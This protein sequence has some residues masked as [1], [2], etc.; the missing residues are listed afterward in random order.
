MHD[1]SMLPPSRVVPVVT[2]ASVDVVLRASAVAGLLCDVPG[3]YVVQHDVGPVGPGARP[4]E[5]ADGGTRLRRTVHARS[6]VVEQTDVDLGHGC[7]S[8]ALREDVLPTLRRLAEDL[9]PL[10]VLALPV[11]AEPLP[12]VRALQHEGGRLRAGGVVTVVDADSLVDDLLGADTLAERGRDLFA[13][14]ERAL[15]EALAHQVELSDVV[16]TSRP[17]GPAASRLLAHLATPRFPIEVRDVHDLAPGR[18]AAL[19]RPGHDPRGDVQAVRPAPVRDG[20]GVWTLDLRAGRP[21]HPG[22]V[23]DRVEDLGRGRIRARGHMWLPSR[24]G[25]ACAWDGAGG[26]LSIGSVGPWRRRAG[27]RIVVTGT[28]P[29]DRSRLTR[30]FRGLELTDDEAA[31]GTHWW[32]RHGDDLDP[33]LGDAAEC[34]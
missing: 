11:A 31:R 27:T 3:A 5:D 14:D 9:P 2:V 25:T 13:G 10:L 19:L 15:G 1:G 7:L 16:A 8:C 12:V 18:L 30:A 26:Q 6:G 29:A 28:D 32:R 22:R 24:P 34:A 4:D 20:D 23:L 17:P 33:W 21:L